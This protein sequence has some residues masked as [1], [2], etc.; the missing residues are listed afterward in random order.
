MVQMLRPSLFCLV[1]VQLKVAPVSD[2]VVVECDVLFGGAWSGG[3]RRARR[4]RGENIDGRTRG[5][6]S[7]RTHVLVNDVPLLEPSCG[8]ANVGYSWSVAL[9]HARNLSVAPKSKTTNVPHLPPVG[10]ELRRGQLLQVLN[11]VLGKA[12]DK[13]PATQTIIQPHLDHSTR[14]DEFVFVT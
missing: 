13:A 3:G 5:A 1:V 8:G 2:F 14:H 11:R 4:V 10:S 9:P 12:L 6:Q 7:P